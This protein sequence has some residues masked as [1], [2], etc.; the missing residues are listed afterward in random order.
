[1][2]EAGFGGVE[3][4]ASVCGG[5]ELRGDTCVAVGICGRER[6]EAERSIG[7][8]D[9][10]GRDVGGGDAVVWFAAAIAAVARWH[11][12]WNEHGGDAAE[13]R[14]LSATWRS[15]LGKCA[16]IYACT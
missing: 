12:E 6:G 7:G 11:A 14:E 3:G 10:G 5:S 1:M 9:C 2:H 4:R 8:A 15:V 13:Q 16:G